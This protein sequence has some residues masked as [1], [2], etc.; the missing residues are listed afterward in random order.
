MEKQVVAGTFRAHCICSG[1]FD[2]AEEAGGVRS[3][4]EEERREKKE[5]KER[6]GTWC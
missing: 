2:W 5:E 3:W 6:A 4:E 1:A